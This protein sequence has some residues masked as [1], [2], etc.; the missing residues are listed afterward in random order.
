MKNQRRAHSYK[1]AATGALAASTISFGVVT[2][3]Q[4][5]QTLP[6]IAGAEAV[7]GYPAPVQHP[8]AP[9]PVPF[10]S[11]YMGGFISDISSHDYG[12][13]VDVIDGFN[14]LRANHPDVMRQNLA[15]TIR[16]NNEAA[17]NPAAI[18]R[19]QMDAAADKAGL[20]TAFSDALGEELGGHF[21][22]AL[23][24]NRLPKTNY[25]FG[26]GYLAR[27]GGLASSTFAEKTYYGY[28][29]PFVVAPDKINRY[30]LPGEDF[31]EDSK[32]F[33]SGHTNQAT[34]STTL[35]AL[36]VPELGPQLVARGSE[37]GYNRMVMGVHY[38]LDV[39]GGRMT[40]TAAAADRWNDPKMRDAVRQAGQEIKAELE[41]RT[42]KPLAEAVA[43]DSPYRSTDEAVDEYTERMTNGFEQVYRNDAPMIVPQA[44]PDLLLSAHPELS[45]AQRA[46]VLRQTA[47]Q[48]GYPLDDQSPEGSW[49]RLNIA[50]A[51]A[52]YVRVNADG[53]VTVK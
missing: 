1:M 27:A 30:N 52:A 53:S 15:T 51:M 46:S 12:V 3:A 39:I 29:R 26:N 35:L 32:A 17:G 24:E 38:P 31:Y 19:A 37:A 5:E 49:Q 22:D 40:G 42:G 4:A 10:S 36:A 45:Y 2:P 16:I 33:P 41:W 7:P 21:R 14:D 23:R 50:A 25:L 47:I 28:E 6:A 48:S 20:L 11:D 34:W 43:E 18:S 13:Y 8:G 9:T 44:A